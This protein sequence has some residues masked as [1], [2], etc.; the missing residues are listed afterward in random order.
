MLSSCNSTTATDFDQNLYSW[1]LLV[2]PSCLFYA[3]Y[4][5]APRLEITNWKLGAVP[6]DT[7]RAG[8]HFITSLKIIVFNYHWN[9]SAFLDRNFFFFNPSTIITCES[10]VTVCYC[11]WCH[12]GY[13]SYGS[14]RRVPSRAS[15][16]CYALA[17]TGKPVG[18]Q[19]NIN[20]TSC[21]WLYFLPMWD[22]TSR[23]RDFRVQV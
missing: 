14:L 13:H 16:H 9:V 10:R 2:R 5:R 12:T 7:L 20:T 19:T 8:L 21:A 4:T 23:V 15:H 18:N 17:P 22:F 3:L 11:L 1:S 6:E